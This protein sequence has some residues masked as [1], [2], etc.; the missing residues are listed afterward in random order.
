MQGHLPLDGV[1]AEG[2]SLVEEQ[3][4]V[5]YATL[6]KHYAK[7]L[8]RRT[9]DAASRA[10]DRLARGAKGDRLLPPVT[11]AAQGEAGEV[12]DVTRRSSPVEVCRGGESNP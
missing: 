8:P 9:N 5:V 6:K 10:L 2:D 3:T 1:A 11:N 7:W 12:R 4:G